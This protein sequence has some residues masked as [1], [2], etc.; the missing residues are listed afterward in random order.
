MFPDNLRMGLDR[1]AAGGGFNLSVI[2][3]D[4]ALPSDFF[5][6][7]GPELEEL[8][9]N[10]IRGLFLLWSLL[11]IKIEKQNRL[12]KKTDISLVVGRVYILVGAQEKPL[13][14]ADMRELI[15]QYWFGC[16]LYS[17]FKWS[18]QV[19]KY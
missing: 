7:S 17:M 4:E 1:L 3:D 5:T 16:L 14:R 12:K 9:S 11:Q 8:P 18:L 10:T 15:C 13:Q 6:L 2:P 19:R